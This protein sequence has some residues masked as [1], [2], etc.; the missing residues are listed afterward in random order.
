MKLTEQE[1]REVRKLDADQR[2]GYR[3]LRQSSV[4]HAT[5]LEVVQQIAGLRAFQDSVRRVTRWP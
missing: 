5:A 2:R 3:N 4:P 1:R